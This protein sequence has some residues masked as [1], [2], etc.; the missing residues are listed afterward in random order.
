MVASQ[1]EH[2]NTHV[3]VSSF[4]NISPMTTQVLLTLDSRAAAIFTLAMVL[5]RRLYVLGST[6]LQ[7]TIVWKTNVLLVPFYCKT[8]K[9]TLI[10]DLKYL[11]HV[12]KKKV[13]SIAQSAIQTYLIVKKRNDPDIPKH[14]EHKEFIL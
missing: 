8:H 12:V 13:L 9:K 4:I 6:A 2:V 14:I 1:P 10:Y 5:S 11:C 3:L 7:F